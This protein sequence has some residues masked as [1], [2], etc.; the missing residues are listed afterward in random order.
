MKPVL[1]TTKQRGVFFWISEGCLY[2]V[3][4]ANQIER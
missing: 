2:E 3:E 1:V 4:H